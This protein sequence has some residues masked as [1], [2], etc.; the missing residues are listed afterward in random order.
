MNVNS[1]VSVFAGSVIMASLAAAHFT[2]QIDMTK[3]S[4]LWLTAFVGFN[5]F[6]MGFTGFCPAKKIFNLFGAKE[7]NDSCCS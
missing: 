2:G 6:Q 4:W 5:L 1:L 3:M 7:A